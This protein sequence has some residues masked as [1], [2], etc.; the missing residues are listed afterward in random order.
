LQVYR[1][2]ANQTLNGPGSSNTMDARSLTGNQQRLAMLVVRD[3]QQNRQDYLTDPITWTLDTRTLA[4]YTQ[5]ALFGYM[6]D[7][8]GVGMM[9]R[10]TGVYTFPR[11]FNPGTLIGQ[12]WLDT[13]GATKL[14][15]QSTTSGTASGPGTVDILVEDVVPLRGLPYELTNI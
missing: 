14:Q 7:F 15:W 12:G 6:Q 11:Y 1:R 10:P 3:G 13:N 5:A 8:Y 9:P 2:F 4:T